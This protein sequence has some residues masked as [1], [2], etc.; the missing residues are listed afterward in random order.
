MICGFEDDVERVERWED[1]VGMMGA[2]VHYV[3]TVLG[4]FMV[5]FVAYLVAE[6]LWTV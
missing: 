1:G 3:G 2:E 5:F 6:Y 4:L